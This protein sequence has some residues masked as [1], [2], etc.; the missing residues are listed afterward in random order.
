RGPNFPIDT[1]CSSSLVALHLACQGLRNRECDTAL[2][3]G[4]NVLLDPLATVYFSR[5]Q[6]MSPTGRCHAFGAQADGYVRSEGCGLVVLK[7]LSQA[8]ADGDEILSVIRGSA[9]NQDGHSNGFTA[10]NGTA[11]RAVIQRALKQGDIAPASVDAV[12]C[13]GTGTPLGDPIEVAALGDVYG[14]AR[15][16][17]VLIGS[18]KS[19]IG[20][21]EAAAGIAGVL[22]ATIALQH[23]VLPRSLH[24][25]ELNAKIA[26]ASANADV[27]RQ[28]RPW[29]RR[30]HPRRMAIS[31]FGFA[32]TNAHMILEEAPSKGVAAPSKADD[33]PW[34]I[35]ITADSKAA[36]RAGA[37]RLAK[38]LTD[39]DIDLPDAARTLA[40]TR[41]PFKE[42]LV[43]VRNRATNGESLEHAL[44]D[45]ANE[46]GAAT[47]MVTG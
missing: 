12:E 43:L 6:A 25:Q 34:P 1:A 29:P 21:T 13:H 10:P 45:F 27:V 31:S 44:N 38:R 33:G 16:K 3:G 46:Q 4:V 17:P 23:E 2:A 7:R 32:G 11:Q 5:M 40:T 26:W 14:K 9:V 19:N 30:E 42:R 18:V 22:K 8:Q 15:T 37:A 28:N 36:L 39:S 24:S 20:H 47:A 41:T 35:V